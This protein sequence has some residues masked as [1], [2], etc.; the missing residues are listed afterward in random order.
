MRRGFNLSESEFK[1][2][3]LT[4]AQTRHQHDK[5]TNF[6]FVEN[7]KYN[8]HFKC[9]GNQHLILVSFPFKARA[10]KLGYSIAS[11]A[12]PGA[13]RPGGQICDMCRSGYGGT[14]RGSEGTPAHSVSVNI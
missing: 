14:A 2:G 11:P 10:E 3:K 12:S 6:S 4:K 13:P 8:F 5:A 9:E 7:Q 1:F